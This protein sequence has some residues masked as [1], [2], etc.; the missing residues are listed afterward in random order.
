M[1]KKVFFLFIILFL[2][3]SC[4]VESTNEQKEDI[5]D[6]DSFSFDE[7]KT[8]IERSKQNYI[9]ENRFSEL[10]DYLSILSYKSKLYSSYINFIISDLYWNTDYLKEIALYY[11][12][13]ID[14]SAYNIIY[15]D[16]KIGYIIALRIINSN[17]NFLL[18][19]KMYNLL[20]NEFNDLI[21]IPYTLSELAKLYK[22]QLDMKSA[23]IVMQNIVDLS[24]KS[25]NIEENIN[26]TEIKDEIDFFYSKKQWI[27]RDLSKLIEN[28]KQSIIEKNLYKLYQFASKNGFKIILSQNEKD[29]SWGFFDIGIQYRFSDYI[30]FSNKLEDFSSDK[31]AFLKTENWDFPQMST[32]YFYFKKVDYPYDD[33]IDGGWEWKGI[34]FGD[35]F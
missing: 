27:Y 10:I 31:E 29:Q 5:I 6:V 32:W 34:Y 8:S 1:L 25:K 18:K 15:N 30:I 23:V 24:N 21:D 14:N 28:I 12:V 7:L 3:F 20:L 11:M 4:K 35:Y 22:S 33:K 19:E 26:L 13:K 2:F 9:D 17:A 16:Q